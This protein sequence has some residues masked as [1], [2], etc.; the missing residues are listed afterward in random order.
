MPRIRSACINAEEA[1][2]IGLADERSR[3]QVHQGAKR[4]AEGP[5]GGYSLETNP[6]KHVRDQLA[7]AG[8][9]RAEGVH[10]RGQPGGP[11]R[12][13]DVPW[14]FARVEEKVTRTSDPVVADPCPLRAQTNSK[15]Q[16]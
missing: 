16:S 5:L 4:A 9:H 12:L 11:D 14:R 6:L 3:P 13:T 8:S 10:D 1:Q 15:Q 7:T 2:R